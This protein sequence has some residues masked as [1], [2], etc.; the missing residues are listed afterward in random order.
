MSFDWQTEETTPWDEPPVAVPERGQRPLRRWLFLAAGLLGLLL[1]GTVAWAWQQ[2]VVTVT[3]QV[4]SDVLASHA[5]V[6]EAASQQDGELLISVLSGRDER[7]ASDVAQSAAEGYL[8]QRPAL[9]LTWHF[10]VTAPAT[11]TI[12]TAPDFRAAEVMWGENYV[13]DVGNGL[14]ETVTLNHTAV[15]RLGGNRWL[16]TPPDAA[17]WGEEGVVS[18]Q[19]LALAYPARD[20]ALVERL[21]LDLDATLARMCSGQLAGFTCPDGWQIQARLVPSP[22][23]LAGNGRAADG[24][25]RL[26]TPTL[27]GLP[28]SEAAYQALLRGYAA[29]IVAEALANAPT[30]AAADFPLAQTLVQLGLRAPQP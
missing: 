2:R 3:A 1:L 28:D 7:W 23:A 22:A 8:L 16:L 4:D 14:T 13:I 6:R 19:Y 29:L 25:L 24:A 11:P 21:L 9:G 17:F 30:S 15:Y 10:S 26:P 12:T 20:A 5:L 27:V 18:G